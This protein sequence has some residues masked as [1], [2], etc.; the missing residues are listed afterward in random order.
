[1]VHD[2]SN[3]N[4]LEI[5]GLIA[6]LAIDMR[7][8]GEGRDLG[9]RNHRAV[10]HGIAQILQRDAAT[11]SGLVFHHAHISGVAAAAHFF[12]HAAGHRVTSAACRKAVQNAHLL[13]R[14]T[15]LGIG[16]AA[17]DAAECSQR[18]T[19]AQA[20]DEIATTLHD[21]SPA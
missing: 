3:R 1:M 15:A 16:T 13:Q 8:D 14:A 19:S 4:W 7:V 11:C 17:G 21:L 18:G 6:Q 12:G 10:P 2:G 20:F 5:L 9:Q